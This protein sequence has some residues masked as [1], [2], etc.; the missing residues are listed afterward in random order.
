MNGRYLPLGAVLLLVACATPSVKPDVSA[1]SAKP[2]AKY[3]VTVERTWSEATHPLDWPGIAAHFTEAI[4]AT[5]NGSY[6]MFGDGAIA[7]P[8]LEVLS[9]RGDA[10][11]FDEELA[12]AQKRG[13]VGTVFTLD[14]I[15]LVGGKSTAEIDATD[16]Y[17]MLSLAWMPAPSPDWFAGVTAI[18]LKREGRWIEYEAITLY[19][20]D[21]GTN[22]A[23]TYKAAKIAVNPFAPTT[24][25]AAPMFFKEGRRIP[26]GSATI[27]KIG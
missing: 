27:R 9:Q 3:E 13:M 1:S 7:T 26:V 21:S 24:L 20:W 11:P 25:S 6:T 4:G 16:A 19:A 2:A 17:S 12:A 23:K 18:P 5:H 22:D 14:P 10:T 8:G 15:R